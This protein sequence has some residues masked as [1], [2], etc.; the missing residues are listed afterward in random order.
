M[1]A[2]FQNTC[3]AVFGDAPYPESHFPTVRG[4]RGKR[5]RALLKRTHGQRE[6]RED[7]TNLLPHYPRA[8]EC[9]AREGEPDRIKCG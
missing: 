2:R 4:E 9:T 5:V 7:I 8:A 3:P 6:A 1:I